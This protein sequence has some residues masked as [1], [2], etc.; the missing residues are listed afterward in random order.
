MIIPIRMA[1]HRLIMF[2][3]QVKGIFFGKAVQLRESEDFGA[4]LVL[5]GFIIGV[6]VFK[7]GRLVLVPAFYECDYVFKEKGLVFQLSDQ[8]GQLFVHAE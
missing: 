5:S 4:A 8:C 6:S 1:E 3:E 7:S 2:G